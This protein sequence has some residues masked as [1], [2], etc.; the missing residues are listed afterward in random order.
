[1]SSYVQ[2]LESC[3]MC[4]FLGLPKYLE[5]ARLLQCFVLIG[6]HFHVYFDCKV[7]MILYYKP[8]CNANMRLILAVLLPYGGD[9]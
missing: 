8:D 1:M 7:L 3:E 9:L 6:E 2:V 4:L 5:N